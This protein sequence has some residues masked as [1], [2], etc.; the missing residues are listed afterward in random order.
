MFTK[1]CSSNRALPCKRLQ[2]N[3][4]VRVG[5]FFYL[6]YLKHTALTIFE[7]FIVWR[8]GK[9][10]FSDVWKH[11]P[12]RGV[13]DFYDQVSEPLS[14]FS[15]SKFHAI[16]SLEILFLCKK[17][18]STLIKVWPS[19]LLE[20]AVSISP[21]VVRLWMRVINCHMFM[22]ASSTLLGIYLTR[23][24]VHPS[25]F[26]WK[27]IEYWFHAITALFCPSINA[28]IIRGS[29]LIILFYATDTY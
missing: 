1:Q 7:V 14:H 2:V 20:K 27:S 29:L 25:N 3:Q 23:D 5:E 18:T 17:S 28:N 21:V 9:I 11:K 13:F 4:S 26:Y 12:K 22:S 24:S 10:S 8:C 16:G 6:K 15:Q 19:S